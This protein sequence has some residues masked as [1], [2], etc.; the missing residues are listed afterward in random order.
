MSVTV[1]ITFSR[2]L[3]EKPME[4]GKGE[5]TK[6]YL[7]WLKLCSF[8]LLLMKKIGWPECVRACTNE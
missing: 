4:S 6:P 3:W 5:A 2:A 7:F 1:I 8:L